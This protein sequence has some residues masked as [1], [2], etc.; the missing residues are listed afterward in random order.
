MATIEELPDTA[1]QNAASRSLVTGRSFDVA[2]NPLDSISRTS[3]YIAHGDAITSTLYGHN[4]FG[5]GQPVPQ[6]TEQYGLTFFTK[7]RLNL[8][9]DNIIKTRIL[10]PLLMNSKTTNSSIMAAIRAILD[11]VGQHNPATRCP[12]INTYNP[13]IPLLDNNLI[14][15]SGWPDITVDKYVSKPGV[16]REKWS[17]ADGVAAYYD[18]FELTATF[19]NMIGDPIG[20]LFHFWTKYQLL[21]HEGVIDPHMDALLENE[22]DYQTRIYRLVLSADRRYVE[23]IGACGVAYPTSSRIGSNFDYNI[24]KPYNVENDQYSVS[25]SCIGAEYLDPITVKEFNECVS[26]FNVKMS[27]PEIRATYYV[28]VSAIEL[29]IFKNVETYPRI[30]PDT[31]RLEWWVDKTDYQ[32]ILGVKP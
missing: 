12:L 5:F 29:P 15:L 1:I 24:E 8:S 22:I 20:R 32:N 18:E 11:P 6:N 17:M 3:G 7:P 4:Q 2:N 28:N 27:T 23:K 9:Y 21:V 30:D 19:R 10:T 25:F 16:Y 13:F 14:T 31:M 26:Q